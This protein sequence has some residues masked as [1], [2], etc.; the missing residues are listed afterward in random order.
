MGP[1]PRPPCVRLRV[2][3]PQ[4][5]ALCAAMECSRRGDTDGSADASFRANR[6]ADSAALQP[7]PSP[8]VWAPLLARARA[9]GKGKVLVGGENPLGTPPSI[10][11]RS[12]TTRAKRRARIAQSV[13]RKTL[14]L[15][16]QGCP[17]SRGDLARNE[18]VERSPLFGRILILVPEPRHPRL[19][20]HAGMAAP[21]VWEWGGGR[22]GGSSI[23]VEDVWP[24]YCQGL[25]IV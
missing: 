18:D 23:R 17:A 25:A 22:G 3:G 7:P 24:L 20:K 8:A 6:S 1:R 11:S 10:N 19:G 12:F 14:N 15:V 13:E 2:S 21:R 9:G 5:L 4:H 16:V